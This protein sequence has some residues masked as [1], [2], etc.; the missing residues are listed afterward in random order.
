MTIYK[1]QGFVSVLFTILIMSYLFFH[2][3]D[4]EHA[5]QSLYQW[6]PNSTHKIQLLWEFFDSSFNGVPLSVPYKTN[7]CTYHILQKAS[8]NYLLTNQV[9]FA[10]M[11]KILTIFFT[12][13]Y[14]NILF[15]KIT[16]P[17]L[18]M[19]ILYTYRYRW[20][21]IIWIKYKHT[22]NFCV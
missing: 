18:K 13:V 9:S 20:K 11:Q 6:Y 3:S 15:Q 12:S 5:I 1:N 2:L 17:I 21:L 22:L 8:F 7:C 19:Y 14:Y 16:F 10:Y 4:F